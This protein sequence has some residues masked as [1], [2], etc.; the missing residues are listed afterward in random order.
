VGLRRYELGDV[1]LAE[2]QEVEAAQAGAVRIE[3][4]DFWR[5][6]RAKKT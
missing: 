5:G 6:T 1:L 2:V 4:C 3:V